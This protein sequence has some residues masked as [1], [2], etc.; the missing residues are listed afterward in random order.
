[1]G[2]PRSNEEAPA[3]LTATAGATG[4]CE[5]GDCPY[6][7]QTLKVAFADDVRRLR[8]AWP[9]DA[10]AAE[11]LAT[12]HIA[13]HEGFGYAGEAAPCLALRYAENDGSAR[14]L[15]EAA[16]ADFI[17]LARGGVLKLCMEAEGPQHPPHLPHLGSGLA[18][19]AAPNCS[20]PLQPEA[21]DATSLPSLW[22]DAVAADT[23]MAE[24]FVIATP[25]CSPRCSICE[26]YEFVWSIVEAPSPRADEGATE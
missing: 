12:I 19:A 15:T 5:S 25:P 7:E 24:G 2:E 16:V 8:V 14:A 23:E 11:I 10:S 4:E 18:A 20:T 26:E 9:A 1:M 6:C 17:S 22:H 21:M 13:A 3:A